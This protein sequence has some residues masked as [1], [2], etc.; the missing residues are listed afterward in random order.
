MGRPVTTP[1]HLCVRLLAKEHTEEAI[2]TLVHIMRRGQQEKSKLA[3]A[4]ALLDRGWGKPAQ[5]IIG[6]DAGPPLRI[7]I[8][9][10]PEEGEPT[11]EK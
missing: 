7:I 9:P 3:A 6:D 2:H 4:N 11:E 5:A 1:T 8:G 10:E